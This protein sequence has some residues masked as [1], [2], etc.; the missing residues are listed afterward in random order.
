L[1]L[2]GVEPAYRRFGIGRRLITHIIQSVC[3]N[4]RSNTILWNDVYRVLVSQV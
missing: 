2:L 1:N 3:F 4:D